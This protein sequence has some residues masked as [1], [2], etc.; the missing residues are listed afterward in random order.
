MDSADGLGLACQN[1]GWRGDR[2]DQNRC[3]ECEGQLAASYDADAVDPE[4]VRAADD[5]LRRTGGASASQWVYERLLP[6]DTATGRPTTLGEGATPL[7]DA[8]A[9]ADELEVG[10]LAI[11]DEGHNPTGTLADRACSVAVTVARDAGATDV[12]L[13]TTGG[14]GVA[15]AA[16]AARAG[17]DAHV[18]VPTRSTHTTKA[19]INVHGGDMSVVEGRLPDAEGSFR[20]ALETESDWTAI[21]PANAPLRTAG[22][23]T[24]YPEIVA[25]LD[26]VAPDHVVVPTGHG[27]ALAGLH[28]A[29]DLLAALGIVDDVPAFHA[30]QADGCAPI[31]DA[32]EVE[33][34]TVT[35]WETPD[36]ICGALE[37]P[38]PALGTL[39]LEAVRNSGGSAIAV[40]DEAILASACRIAAAEGLQANVAGGAA[41]AGAWELMRDGAFGSDDDVVLLNTGAGSLDS[42]VLRSHL[43]RA[44]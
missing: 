43:M 13:P 38:D 6:T 17:L 37:V 7:V 10:T 11:K 12:A 29:A 40:D 31:A 39:A 32:A 1:C 25:S 5:G 21:D 8:P 42:D 26:R 22:I 44:G 35:A 24:A 2:I 16:Y 14:D 41:A 20:S 28:A 15:A 33:A 27:E 23:A 19:M 30:V 36:T 9:L 3:P 34:D 4:G 18:F